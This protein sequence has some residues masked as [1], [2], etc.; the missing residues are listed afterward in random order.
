MLENWQ[1]H[2]FGLY[3]HWPFCQAKCPY[4]DFNSY[5]S[6]NIEIS[7][8]ETAF[9]AEIEYW[10]AVTG[11]RVL[12]SVYFGGGTPSLMPPNLVAAIID[13]AASLWSLANDCEITL[14]ANPT[15]VEATK[16]EGFKAAGVNRISMG[17]QALNDHDLKALG[18]LHS[19][20]E[21]LKALDTAQSL[22]ERVN[23]DLIYGRQ[24]QSKQDWE[25]ELNQAIN[26]NPSH[27]SLYQLT[28]ESGTRFADLYNAGKLR[29]LPDEDHGADLYELTQE[30]TQN[31]GLPSYEVSNHARSG[32]QSQ[33]NLIYW[34]A[35]D[36]IGIGPGAHGRYTIRGTRYATETEIAPLTWLD[37]ATRRSDQHRT[38]ITQSR[39]D[40]DNEVLMMGLRTN[41]G[42]DLT[43]LNLREKEFL[44]NKINLL[45]EDALVQLRSDTLFT[46]SNGKL[47]LNH[48][49]KELL[50]Q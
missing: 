11:P 9:L 50:V 42:V 46:T 37:A 32:E 17:F 48:V 29:G 35:G 34:R 39:N 13:K 31:A 1:Q 10:A 27:M 8:W 22:F 16:F 45:S 23:F 25:R 6:D 12:T 15:S 43:R 30:I 38:R 19:V 47:L 20:D 41:E 5:V 3:V 36:Y 7:A 4:C 26:L 2:G 49:I 24:N 14:E 44:Y 21:S 33:H 18:R 28:I 40:V